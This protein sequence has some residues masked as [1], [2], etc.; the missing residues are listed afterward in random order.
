[1]FRKLL[2]HLNVAGSLS[3][4]LT[5]NFVLL[6][7]IYVFWLMLK[8]QRK[9]KEEADKI[10]S[11]ISKFKWKIYTI[12]KWN[13]TSSRNSLNFKWNCWQEWKSDPNSAD[14]ITSHR[15][16]D[17]CILVEYTRFSRWF[18]MFFFHCNESQ[19][20]FSN[21]QVDLVDESIAIFE[22][23]RKL[24]GY[25]NNMHI[26]RSLSYR[27]KTNKFDSLEVATNFL[28]CLFDTRQLFHFS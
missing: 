8:R 22:I 14:Q 26:R 13:I 27:K 5:V 20:S 15:S 4:Y 10:W 6:I 28:L 12:P 2:G 1:M 25:M 19:L 11:K 9:K 3:W 16:G 17:I 7:F 24:T 18:I 23:L 21:N